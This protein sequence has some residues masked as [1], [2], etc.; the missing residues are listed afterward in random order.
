LT[1]LV[2]PRA[3]ALFNTPGLHLHQLCSRFP[4]S[5]LQGD[6][7]VEGGSPVCLPKCRSTTHG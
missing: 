3:V 7:F 1:Q 2:R 5:H 6:A 4:S